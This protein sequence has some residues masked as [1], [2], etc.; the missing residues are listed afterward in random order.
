MND[1]FT[2]ISDLRSD[3]DLELLSNEN[4]IVSEM[5]PY[6]VSDVNTKISIIKYIA[7]AYDANSN[8]VK[9][10]H[11]REDIK[12]RAA[13]KSQLNLLHQE[14]LSIIT[15]SNE[16]VNAAIGVYLDSTVPP[17]LK[18]IITG[19]EVHADMLNTLRQFRTQE[20]SGLD[21]LSWMKSVEARGSS[22][23]KTIEVRKAINQLREEMKLKDSGI[24]ETGYGEIK[25]KRPEDVWRERNQDQLDEE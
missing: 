11:D 15:N 9:T 18:T 19:E 4:V 13:K 8:L 22:F 16:T 3:S 1:L 25:E 6:L 17:E 7:L 14:S 21:Y 5:M 2:A 23:L 24:H 20:T 12:K 10:Y